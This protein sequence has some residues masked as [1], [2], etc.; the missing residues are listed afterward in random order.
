L[1][2]SDFKEALFC[3]E[4]GIVDIQSLIFNLTDY[5]LRH[6]VAIHTSTEFQIAKAEDDLFEVKTNN[7]TFMS[8]ILVNAGGA[9][10]AVAAKGANA[11][12]IQVLPKR[13]HVFVSEKLE[14]VDPNWPIVWDVTHDVYFRTEQQSLVMSPCDTEDFKAGPVPVSAEAK[15]VLQEKLRHF[16]PRAQDTSFQKEWAGLRT[17]SEDKRFVIGWDGSLRNFFWVSC[18]NGHGLTTCA[19]VGKLAADLLM[20][21]PINPELETLLSPQRFL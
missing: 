6:G 15:K 5:C 17:F 7:K 10:A 3:S 9:W 4:D 13:R 21:R 8:R 12:G 18:L 16:L 20:H 1:E 14:W 2:K 11:Q 19:Y